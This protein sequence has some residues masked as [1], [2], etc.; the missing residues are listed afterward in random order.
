M[1]REFLANSESK[2]RTNQVKIR[3]KIVNFM[4]TTLNRLLGTP[5]IDSQPMKELLLRPLYR[6]IKH[7]LSGPNSGW[8]RCG[9]WQTAKQEKR[10]ALK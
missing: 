6:E 8:N 3:G 2:E 1:V 9:M 4:P 7:S 5:S 10:R